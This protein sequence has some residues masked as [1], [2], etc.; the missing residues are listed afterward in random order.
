MSFSTSNVSVDG[1]RVSVKRGGAGEP[2][3]FLHGATGAAKV[4]PFMERL[5]ERFDVIVPEHPGFG[6]SDDP[7]WLEN[8]A[9]LAYFYLDFLAAQD[10]RRV[11]VV[12]GSIGGWIALE[13]AV[14]DASRFATLALIGS[15]GIH[16]KGVP[17][18]DLFLWSPEET[19]R[20][21]FFDPSIAERELAERLTPE[22]QESVLKNKYTVAKLAWEP[23]LHDPFLYKWLKR[24]HVPTKI[25]WGDSDRMFP[26]Q[27]GES[28]QKMIPGADLTVIR[29]CGHLP[30]VERPDEFCNTLVRFI[31]S[32]RT[33]RRG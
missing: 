31:D 32:A 33:A 16:L 10:L 19:I 3:L 9:D 21:A 17:T 25:I 20:N 22:Q 12:G 5:A 11:H 24:I 30:H 4:L 26:L 29:R 23:R 1:C 7:S 18:G 6:D 2:L 27:Y 13:M 28:F 15:A 8:I 14:R